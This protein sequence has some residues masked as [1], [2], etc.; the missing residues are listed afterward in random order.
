MSKEKNIKI[1]KTINEFNQ[2]LHSQDILPNKSDSNINSFKS[3]NI[4]I[5]DLIISNSIRNKNKSKKLKCINN[6]NCTSMNNNNLNNLIYLQIEKT[7]IFNENEINNH[8]HH[9][10]HENYKINKKKY[11]KNDNNNDKNIINSLANNNYFENHRT[12]F[13]NLIKGSNNIPKD[14]GPLLPLFKQKNIKDNFIKG[15]FNKLQNVYATGPDNTAYNS[16]FSTTVI[17]NSNFYINIDNSLSYASS[18]NSNLSNRA[19]NNLNNNNIKINDFNSSNFDNNLKDKNTEDLMVTDCNNK[20]AEILSRNNYINNNST[21]LNSNLNKKTNIQSPLKIKNKLIIVNNKSES[22]RK[23]KFENI[24][25]LIINSKTIN[26][27]KRKKRIFECTEE[28]GSKINQA[29]KK[30]K[31]KRRFRKS[32]DQLKFLSETFKINNKNWSKELITQVSLKSGLSE[33]KVYKW[34]WDQKNKEILE[35]KPG[36]IFHVRN[37]QKGSE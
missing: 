29:Q 15:N 16:N 18:C 24:K 17:S 23:K 13:T 5:D 6:N 14:M 33:N 9:E 10:G 25:K 32:S 7:N 34:F 12:P 22:E 35:I 2:N 30:N 8:N 26:T 11:Y 19:N 28:Y 20:N 21:I 36:C 1:M 31:I 27:I 4:N 37:L 3:E